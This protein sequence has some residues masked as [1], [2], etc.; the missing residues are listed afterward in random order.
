MQCTTLAQRIDNKIITSPYTQ[1]YT[2][3]EAVEDD[4]WVMKVAK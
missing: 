1:K 3:S 2:P 4:F